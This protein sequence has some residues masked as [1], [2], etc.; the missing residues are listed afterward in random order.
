MINQ[1]AVPGRG[2]QVV[3]D[4]AAILHRL[5]REHLV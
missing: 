2:T 1:D 3:V 4:D 5:D